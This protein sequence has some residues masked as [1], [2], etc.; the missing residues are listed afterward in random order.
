MNSV[1]ILVE[2]LSG[3]IEVLIDVKNVEMIFNG[4]KKYISSD[5][6]DELIRIIR[7]W[8]CDYGSNSG[9]IDAEAFNIKINMDDGFE[10]I[11]G[12]GNYPE[13]YMCFK[14][15]LGSFYD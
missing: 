7:S 2:N 1:E 5:N 4:K 15:W 10:I 12:K 6:I 8:K 11:K 13:N 14:A 9:S 3:N